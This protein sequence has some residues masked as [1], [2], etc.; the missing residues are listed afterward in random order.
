MSEATVKGQ[1]LR[2]TE[3]LKKD[4]ASRIKV[5]DKLKR[6]KKYTHAEPIIKTKITEFQQKHRK[7]LPLRLIAQGKGNPFTIEAY[8][9]IRRTEPNKTHSPVAL[10]VA[11]LIRKHKTNTE[12]KYTDYTS[13][14]EE[15]SI[16]LQGVEAMKKIHSILKK[17]SIHLNIITR[18]LTSTHKN[19]DKLP[20]IMRYLTTVE[21][22]LKKSA[23]NTYDRENIHQD[24]LMKYPVR[25]NI[26][27]RTKRS[28]SEI[29]TDAT[30][31]VRK[32]LRPT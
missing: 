12:Y 6:T 16:V 20:D 1:L 26:I 5:I 28:I 15:P 19:L 32:R 7:T 2:W 22:A 31:F 9:Q 23:S 25:Q 30:E 14:I 24:A 18:L 29:A 13:L 17:I 11:E 10:Q 21:D 27:E 8:Q 4:V 3:R